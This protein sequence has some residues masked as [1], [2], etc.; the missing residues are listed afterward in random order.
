M[1]IGRR[2]GCIFDDR[3]DLELSPCSLETLM[4]LVRGK[5]LSVDDYVEVGMW[6]EIKDYLQERYDEWKKLRDEKG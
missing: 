3:V 4:R 1:K 2:E 5:S 6:R